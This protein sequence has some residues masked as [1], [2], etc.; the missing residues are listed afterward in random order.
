LQARYVR[1]IITG[2]IAMIPA[3]LCIWVTQVLIDRAI[4]P[5]LAKGMDPNCA[6]CDYFIGGLL[7]L[8]LIFALAGAATVAWCGSLVSSPVQSEKT[9]GIAGA[10]A[11]AGSFAVWLPAWFQQ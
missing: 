3:A 4:K 5:L 7:G 2:L 8:A 11:C 10:V 9:A 6:G 1:A